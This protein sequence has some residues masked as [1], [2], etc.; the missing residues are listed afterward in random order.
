MAYEIRIQ[1]AEDSRKEYH[2]IYVQWKWARQYA[3]E[4]FEKLSIEYPK[5]V[6]F[7]NMC[8]RCWKFKTQSRDSII[9]HIR[10]IDLNYPE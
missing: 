5:N 2:W 8:S 9:Q 7:T 1:D 4:L 3:K 6:Y 10:V